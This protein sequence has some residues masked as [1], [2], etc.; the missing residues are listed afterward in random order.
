MF[1]GVVLEHEWHVHQIPS[2]TCIKMSLPSGQ[3]FNVWIKQTKTQTPLIQSDLLT[4]KMP[5]TQPISF[6][7]RNHYYILRHRHECFHTRPA[8][9]WTTDTVLG[10]GNLHSFSEAGPKNRGVAGC[11]CVFFFVF[12]VF[13][14]KSF[15]FSGLSW[16][17][18]WQTLL[19]SADW[20]VFWVT[21]FGGL[22]ILWRMQN[23]PK[24]QNI[25]LTSILL[26]ALSQCRHP[27]SLSLFFFF[28]LSLSI[29]I[30][31]ALCLCLSLYLA[32]SLFF[33]F[34]LSLS[35]S[36]RAVCSLCVCLGIYCWKHVWK[37]NSETDRER[38]RERKREREKQKKT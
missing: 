17:S 34:S 38:E 19:A 30:P 13:F 9:K 6:P 21:S 22:K 24:K 37:R 15:Y 27:L 12:C 4:I 11:V 5:W 31:L 18:L 7:T 28:S 16:P 36:F 26:S 32:L 29:S 25:N 3:L 2:D 14:R 33:F 35:L 20:E 23:P 10:G 1:S 8:F